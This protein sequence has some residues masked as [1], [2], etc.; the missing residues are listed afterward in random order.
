[1]QELWVAAGGTPQ[2]NDY[3]KTDKDAAAWAVS[4]A[5]G[6]PN[7]DATVAALNNGVNIA[8]YGV[9]MNGAPQEF[10]VIKSAALSFLGVTMN[11][12]CDGPSAQTG[13][14]SPE[15]LDYLWR[16]SGNPGQD[17]VTVDPTK[18]PY[19]YCK[20][21]GGA[22]PLNKDGTVNQANVTMANT[23]GAI[24]NV[25]TYYQNIF[26]RTQDNSDFDAQAA[27][28]RDCYNVHLKVPKENTTD[29][30]APNPDEWQ[31]IGSKQIAQP[32]VFFVLKPGV[33]TAADAVPMCT[34]YGAQ[35]AT[36]AQVATAQQQGATWCGSGWVSDS[37]TIAPPNTGCSTSVTGVNCF[38]T[39]PATGTPDVLPFNGSTWRNPASMPAGWVGDNVILAK[40]A[41]A[42]NIM[43]ASAANATSCLAFP[44]EQQCGD[45]LAANKTN[46]P[47]ELAVASTMSGA[48][49]QYIRGRV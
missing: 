38:G 48:I 12:P 14:H 22:A 28:M 44:S 27:A 4:D 26:N 49:D 40:E 39:K 25:R 20:K 46:M 18:L 24:P 10:A 35:V 11:S 30:P 37:T 8:M 1:M 3:P 7:L 33:K 5:S 19:A 32:E 43:C 13:P 31:C 9:D 17:G 29:C 16:T 21:D 41:G 36:T 15:C 47:G 6:N 42:T 34:A 23:Y 45:F 2:G